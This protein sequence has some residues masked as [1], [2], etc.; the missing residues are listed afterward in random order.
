[1]SRRHACA[2]DASLDACSG[3]ALVAMAEAALLVVEQ[4]REWAIAGHSVLHVLTGGTVPK[5]WQHLPDGDARDARSGY[6]WY[7]HCHDARERGLG[8]HQEHGHFHLFSENA[9]SGRDA[10]T[11]THLIAIGLDARGQPLRAFTVNRWVTDEVWR[12][13]SQV[14]RLLTRFRVD[15]EGPEGEISR[16]LSALTRLFAPQLKQIVIE[17]DA[18]MYRRAS[19]GRRPNLRDDRRLEVI[20]ECRLSLVHQIEAIDVRRAA[21]R[22]R[23]PRKPPASLAQHE[24]RAA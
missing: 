8:P 2:L 1:M 22:S 10:P 18:A 13:A 3:R 12:D 24:E 9:A 14:L 15:R 16:W 4:T 20:S 17:R 7:Y 6:R 11:L 23:S 21:A 19:G 5:A